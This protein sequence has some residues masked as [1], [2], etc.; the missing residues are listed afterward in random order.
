[1]STTEEELRKQLLGEEEIN[2]VQT[3][4]RDLGSVKTAE[5]VIADDTNEYRKQAALI[6]FRD[7]KL[8][9]LP[10]RGITLPKDTRISCRGL[11]LEEIK[12]Y[13]SMNEEEIFD[14]EEKTGEIFDSCI[15]IYFG[16]KLKSWKDISQTN[17][18][19]LLF[20]LR[21]LT[22][23]DHGRDIKLYHTADAPNGEKVKAEITND[24]FAYNKIPD[25]IMK[26]YNH[27]ERLFIVKDNGME[28]FRFSIPTMGVVYHLKKYIIE[29]LEKQR[30]GE[31]GGNYNRQ[32]VDKYAEWLITDWRY[33]DDDF[34]QKLHQKYA[35]FSPDILD[36]LDYLHKNFAYNVKPTV[37]LSYSGGEKKFDS[38][39]TFPRGIANLFSLSDISNRLFGN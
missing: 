19:F 6:G 1:M 7:V 16:D 25:G 12:H 22:M 18:I 31:S 15:R 39:I 26:F 9:I 33:I 28:I 27:D 37:E 35:T 5:Q 4:F 34:M 23:Q 3:G 14:I 29:K 21:D 13:S 36:I 17:R 10:D 2:T 32:L 38:V 8:D 11:T 30:R 24:I 20:F